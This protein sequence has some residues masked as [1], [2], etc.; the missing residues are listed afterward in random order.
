MYLSYIMH[1]IFSRL[2]G[3]VPTHQRINVALAIRQTLF[4]VVVG[5]I[6]FRV[7]LRWMDIA[8]VV[9]VGFIIEHVLIFVKERKIS[10]LSI[11]S[12]NTSL[13]TALMLGT[14]NFFVYVVGLLIG[15][16]QKHYLRIN[17]QHFLNPSNV[18]IVVALLFFPNESFAIA[19]P[20]GATSYWW[21][22]LILIAG[23]G[24]IVSKV[25]LLAVPVSFAFFY[26]IFAYAF[27]TRN[28]LEITIMMGSGNFIL[29]AFYMLGDPKAV[30]ATMRFR[31]LFAAICAFLAN[32]LPSLWGP[33]YVNFFLALML[34]EF[35]VPVFRFLET[36][37]NRAIGRT[38]MLAGIG[39]L[40]AASL[41]LY[42]SPFNY[43]RNLAISFLGNG[44][45][46]VELEGMRETLA[47]VSDAQIVKIWS[48]QKP[49]W[50]KTSWDKPHVETLSLSRATSS[51]R[52]LFVSTP[53][54]ISS[55]QPILSRGD[56]GTEYFPYA[57]ATA[58]D[59]NHDGYLDIV[60]SKVRQKLRVYINDQQGDFIDSTAGF[61][62]G[63]IPEDVEYVA[64]SDVNADSWLDLFVVFSQYRGVK[65]NTLFIFNS[66]RRQWIDSGAS[67]GFG[68]KSTGGISLWDLNKDKVLD[69]YV[70]YGLDDL[71]ERGDFAQFPFADEF[72][73][74]DGKAWKEAMQSYFPPELS[75]TSYIGMTALFT[76]FTHDGLVDFLL[77]NDTTDP[78]LTLVGRG[79]G[80]IR[81]I[82][83]NK[84]AH[85]TWSSMSYFPADF[86]NDGIFELFEAGISF[87]AS[88]ERK[89][90]I[91]SADAALGGIFGA[92]TLGQ[93]SRYLDEFA[94]AAREIDLGIYQCERFLN[95]YVAAT[96][97]DKRLTM[98]ATQ[99]NDV[100]VCEQIIGRGE[101]SIC[102]REV[103]ILNKNNLPNP[104]YI[105]FDAEKFPKKVFVNSLLKLN[106]KS[107]RYEAIPL[108]DDAAYTNWTW[109]AYP[110]DVNNDGR[111]DLYMTSGAVFYS[112]DRGNKVLMNESSGGTIRMVD[113]TKE[114]GGWV[115]DDTRG[116]IIADFRNSGAGD[117]V[118]NNFMAAPEYFVNTVSGESI[119]IELRSKNS[120]YYSIG[121][122]ITLVTAN[123]KQ[124]REMHQGGS[125]NSAQ[126]AIA[127]FGIDKE[128]TIKQLVIRWPDGHM[129]TIFAP[130]PNQR[131]IIYE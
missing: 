80:T 98:M 110:Y 102:R 116:V 82:D 62:A 4:I 52:S 34:A 18:A 127:H 97:A 84:I 58:G 48:W 35:A 53:T 60:L 130:T 44:T 109:T 95:P 113:R 67:F 121:A 16:F 77:G 129:Q 100:R 75:Q 71:S 120:N 87:K 59:I 14:T 31:I 128:D 22:S 111:L 123:G 99:R 24:F 63:Q 32:A 126:P 13:S 96:C 90:T 3:L 86:D 92:K 29:Y 74:S 117:L 11:A 69:F 36:H 28:I 47:V 9:A 64:L 89:S 46:G 61:F 23:A 103:G 37:R 45:I 5:K 83:K 39:V 66:V 108:E 12:V 93:Q 20:L 118:V 43:A 56:L 8:G 55:Y 33:K 91:I 42:I 122:Q 27:A 50:Y 131:Y 105:R 65:Q 1:N 94:K 30:P 21:V 72:Y 73:I 104:L 81:L 70:S 54:T 7:P 124:V 76:D 38:G 107:G 119:E 40:L 85:N 26:A 114:T 101:R 6:L 106:S 25:K 57:G 68:K 41:V 49:E 15:F 78:S 112:H 51:G 19:T 115:N 17:R 2:S 79:D 10:G 88:S 125:W